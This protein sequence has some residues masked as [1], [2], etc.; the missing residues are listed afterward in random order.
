VVEKSKIKCISPVLPLTELKT[1]QNEAGLH[2]MLSIKYFKILLNSQPH[3]L[4]FQGLKNLLKAES[5][6]DRDIS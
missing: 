3:S 1:V 4:L 2:C 5:I 6:E